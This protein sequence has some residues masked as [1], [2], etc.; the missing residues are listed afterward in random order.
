[1][2]QAGYVFCSRCGHA[3]QDA[4]YH[5]AGQ[6]LWVQ[7]RRTMFGRFTVTKYVPPH[8]QGTPEGADSRIKRVRLSSA[9]INEAHRLQH[10]ID[11]RC[12][13]GKK[14]EELTFVRSCPFCVGQRK[15]WNQ[16][17]PII[18]LLGDLPTYVI[19]VAGARS[20]GK[21]CWI[22]AL[23]C[24]TNIN[25]VNGQRN[26]RNTHIGYLLGP[27]EHVDEVIPA[28]NPTQPNERGATSMLYI[29]KRMVGATAVPV[30]QVLVVDFAGELFSDNNESDFD[31]EAAHIFDGGEGYSGVDAVVFM[32]DPNPQEG[33]SLARTYERAKGS[34]NSFK[35]KPL[36]FVMNKAD[37]WVENPPMHHI[38][39]DVTLGEVPLLSEHTFARQDATIYGKEE[40]QERVALQTYILKKEKAL[41]RAICDEMRGAGFLVKS[42]KPFTKK[43]KV[44]NPITNEERETDVAM[45]DFRESMNVMDPLIWILNELDI[46][47]IDN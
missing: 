4:Y 23:A 28:P 14:W 13:D 36:A 16:A 6:Q 1:M 5:N 30:A 47:P 42:T 41:V 8:M 12:Y 22:H 34:Y 21:S 25:R 40:L 45:V 27:A 19:A 24:P 35:E 43:V 39:G 20:V 37:M 3:T 44:K 32:T 18:E 10:T 38:N 46:F 33:Y 31:A 26:N 2:L 29:K 11:V 7:L 17:A 9:N 15:E